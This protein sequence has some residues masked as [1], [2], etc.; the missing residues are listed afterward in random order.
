MRLG[1]KPDLYGD[2]RGNVEYGPA[3]HLPQPS[4]QTGCANLQGRDQKSYRVEGH[5]EPMQAQ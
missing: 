5:E 2:P 4:D 3:R 1:P